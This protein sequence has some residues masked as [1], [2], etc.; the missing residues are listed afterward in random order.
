MQTNNPVSQASIKP[1][2]KSKARADLLY[3]VC[4]SNSTPFS[5]LPEYSLKKRQIISFV[6]IFY[7]NLLTSKLYPFYR[8]LPDN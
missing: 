5:S 4:L 1:L 8:I 3:L 7:P 6:L 2:P